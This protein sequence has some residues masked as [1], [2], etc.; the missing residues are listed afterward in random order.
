MIETDPRYRNCECENNYIHPVNKTICEI[1][2]AEQHDQ[3][4]SRVNEVEDAH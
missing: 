3:P 4:E 1:C 2:K